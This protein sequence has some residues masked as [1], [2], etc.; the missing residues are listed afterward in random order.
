MRS[1]GSTSP[2]LGLHV[3][4]TCPWAFRTWEY[5]FFSSCSPLLVFLRVSSFSHYSLFHITHH[6]I[7]VKFNFFFG[8][9]GCCGDSSA[10]KSGYSH[11]RDA[12]SVPSSHVEPLPAACNSSNKGIQFMASAGFCAH[13]HISPTTHTIK[14]HKNTFL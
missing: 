6:N 14:N 11:S 4:T 9:E 12:G 1:P 5:T 7:Q 3:C 10:V 8:E 2:V 13:M